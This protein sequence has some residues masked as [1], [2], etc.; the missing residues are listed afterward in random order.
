M[1]RTPAITGTFARSAFSKRAGIALSVL[2]LLASACAQSPATAPAA[3]P[4]SA[5][6]AAP[7][8]AAAATGAP[9]AAATGAPAAATDGPRGPG[10][11]AMVCAEKRRDYSDG[12]A[13]R[14]E[15]IP[16]SGRTA[17]GC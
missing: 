1:R 15:Q 6:G 9:A 16:R 3:A 4:T 7:T 12:P 5:A 14:E 2:A 10:R 8:A 13:A 11:C 17:G